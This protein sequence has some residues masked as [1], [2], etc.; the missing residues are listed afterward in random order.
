MT[1]ED[2]PS[3][4]QHT[5]VAAANVAPTF[6]GYA[7]EVASFQNS[8]LHHASLEFDDL[9]EETAFEPLRE[10]GARLFS[11][12]PADI[13]G[14]SSVTE[15]LQSVAWAAVDHPGITKASNIVGTAA[16]FPATVYP[17]TR[18]A[19]QTGA[20][21]RLAQHDSNYY[22]PPEDIMALID[23]NTAVVMLSHVEFTC[24]QLYNLTEFAVKAHSVGAI[25]V[26][27]A[28]QSAGAVPIDAYACGVDILAAAGYKWLCGAFG[29]ALMYVAPHL[30][31]K[32]N[33]GMYGFRSHES[34]WEL[35]AARIKL[36]PDASRF[37][38]ST[39]H[40]GSALGLAKSIHWLCDRG[41]DRVHAHDMA[42]ADRL[43]DG[44]RGMPQ[45]EV[46]SP[47][48]P[49]ERSPITTI[50]IRGVDTQIAV[51]ALKDAK[52]II[53]N[54]SGHLRFA[55][56]VY[57][58]RRDMDSILDQL[59][60]IIISHQPEEAQEAHAANKQGSAPLSGSPAEVC[61]LPDTVLNP[62]PLAEVHP[63]YIDA[64]AYKY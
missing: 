28:T 61:L 7:A 4:R 62:P 44:F 34:M 26:V 48:D 17:W 13:A 24:G 36:K 14:G 40:F 29:A 55:P 5:F 9:A 46:I 53:T 8:L 43:L 15:L 39:M 58:T 30:Q 42:L 49:S 33:P 35:N 2:F 50:R 41:I 3:R 47:G 60:E 32:L 31:T 21:L 6:S 59:R 27:D 37:E 11:C 57:N 63:A 45:V 12:S 20:E 22:T 1:D 51:D 64:P 16:S 38:F 23:E 10:A 52:F 19:E 54:R 18:V 25:L 56:H